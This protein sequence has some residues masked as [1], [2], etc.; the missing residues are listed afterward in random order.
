MPFVKVALLKDKSKPAVPAVL[1]A[2]RLAG[3]DCDPSQ[4]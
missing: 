3:Y 4:L 1:E 2:M